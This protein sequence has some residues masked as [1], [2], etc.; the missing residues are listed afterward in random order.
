[1]SFKSHMLSF[2]YFIILIRRRVRTCC[3]TISQSTCSYLG[4]NL[5]TWHPATS[6]W[7]H[8][9]QLWNCMELWWHSKCVELGTYPKSWLSVYQWMLWLS[10]FGAC[11]QINT[12]VMSSQFHTVSQLGVICPCGC[13]WMSCI[14]TTTK[15]W[16]CALG[17]CSTGSH[18]ASANLLWA[19]MLGRA[20]VCGGR[21]SPLSPSVL[22]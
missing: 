19:Y 20:K 10:W 3:G 21:L 5:N 16:A 1:M 14:Q 18:P 12:F 7:T 15:V 22:Q 2:L 6:P 17:H 13:W 11:A 8:G 4:S 9:A